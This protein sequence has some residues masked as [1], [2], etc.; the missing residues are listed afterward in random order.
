MAHHSDKVLISNVTLNFSL[1]ISAV[2]TRQMAPKSSEFYPSGRDDV[3]KTSEQWL[4]S[5][6]VDDN[7]GPGLWRVH[8]RLYDLRKFA[9]TVMILKYYLLQ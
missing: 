2:V 1:M 6:R 3:I 9:A 8:D 4:D 5:R 7:L